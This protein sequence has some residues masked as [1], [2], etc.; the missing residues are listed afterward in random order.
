M[1]TLKLLPFIALVSLSCTA[2]MESG[3][4]FRPEPSG[5]LP[6]GNSQLPDLM[7]PETPRPTGDGPAE[8]P[9]P[10][11]PMPNAPPSA[12]PSSPPEPPGG[13]PPAPP[14]PPTAAPSGPGEE[15]SGDL[16][17]VPK[18]Y[19]GTLEPTYLPLTPQQILA[20]GTF[21]G[22]SG[23]LITP[24][25][26]LTAAHCGLSAG[27]E[28]CMG[29]EPGS[30]DACISSLRTIDAAGDMTLVELAQDAR[31]LLPDVVPVAILTTNLDQ[32]WLGKTAEMSGYGQSED[33]G[34]GVRKFTAE[35]IVDLSGDTV[36]VD[37]EGRHGVCFGDSG[38]PM[39]VIADDGTVRVAGA[40]SNG[41]GS[42]VGVDNYTRVDSYRDW[43]EGFT[44]PT[45]VE[46]AGCGNTDE[47]GR[48]ING[49]ALFC[50]AG[51][52]RNERCAGT[53]GWDAST[54]GF[55]CI[56]GADPCGGVDAF[57]TCVRGLA[58]FCEAGTLRQ[59]NCVACGQTCGQGPAGVTCLDDPCGG[60]DYL[61]RCD[62]STAVW[63]ENG[64]LETQ[65]C[66]EM[67]SGCGW[68][69]DDTGYFC[70]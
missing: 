9:L 54:S 8:P 27:E 44:G 43:I 70:R 14:S 36:S 34:F 24:T 53:C 17:V 21:G 3:T 59:R 69:D 33:G 19:H 40:L 29:P 18:V 62:G 47:V 1:R 2:Q 6:T 23:L 4:G 11:E 5:S 39:M 46:G 25:W 45:V 35:P 15:C 65:N 31:E 66:A 61:G 28:F 30:P 26:V 60:L 48:C 10:D 42:C 49:A 55:R 67:G 52:L 20:I 58:R 63:C 41:D 22:C 37:G 13:D 56:D 16:R 51:E 12:A 7:D 68:V 64:A 50:D 57:G 32:S 38:G